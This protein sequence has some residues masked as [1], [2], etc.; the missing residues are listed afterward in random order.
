MST[1]FRVGIVASRGQDDQL[2]LE[3]GAAGLLRDEGGASP[4]RG[5]SRVG[6]RLGD[7]IQA[8]GLELLEL[9]LGPLA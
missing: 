8:V 1:L 2:N 3:I 4:G 9:I 6:E 5:R 7:R